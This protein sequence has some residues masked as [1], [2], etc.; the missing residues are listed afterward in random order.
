[1]QLATKVLVLILLAC[2]FGGVSE[3]EGGRMDLE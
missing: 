2:L 1:M 3:R